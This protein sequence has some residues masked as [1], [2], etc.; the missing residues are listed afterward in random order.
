[1]FLI[2]GK[3]IIR[4][5]GS[6]SLML[7]LMLMATFNVNA[8]GTST[9]V[10]LTCKM[11]KSLSVVDVMSLGINISAAVPVGTIV[12]SGTATANFKCA[13][14]NLQQFVDGLSGEVYFKRKA[15]DADALGYGLTLYTGYGGDMGTEVA[16]IPTGIMISTYALTSGGTVGAY[17]DVSLDV[18]YQ[19]VKTSN[20]MTPSKSLKNYV[21]PFDVG[22]LVSGRD[23]TFQFTNIKTGITVKDQTCSVAGDTNLPV[24][25]G[26]YTTNPSSGLGSG[27]GQTSATTAF[28]IQLNCEAL[29][30][31]SFDVMMQLD[32]DASGGLSDLGVVALNSTSTA[33]GVGVQILNE[34]QQPIALATPF[35]IATY[36]LSSALI[37]VPLYARYYQTAAKINP[38][39]ANAVAT[40]TLSYQ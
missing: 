5:I 31:G 24:P 1:M 7:S 22:S 17:T 8:A 4:L 32:G 33:S 6:V 28:N 16:N 40:Y 18:P 10:T 34:N 3:K 37:T 21:N 39:T 19:I 20:S 27:I 30:S 26:S 23:E 12:Y 15:I 9:D 36:P 2:S 11:T 13:L 29:L 25:L 38:G 14:D 35:N